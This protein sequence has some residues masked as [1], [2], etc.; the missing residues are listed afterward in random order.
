VPQED[1]CARE[2]E[3]CRR[4]TASV[5]ECEFFPRTSCHGA[6]DA[7]ADRVQNNKLNHEANRRLNEVLC[8]FTPNPWS[9]KL[10]NSLCSFFAQEGHTGELL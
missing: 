5:R 10:A 9:E 4:A 8:V 3:S 6:R 7:D 1:V 2:K